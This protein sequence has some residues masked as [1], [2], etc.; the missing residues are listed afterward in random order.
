MKQ[1]CTAKTLYTVKH[2]YIYN[3]QFNHIHLKCENILL[4]KYAVSNTYNSLLGKM[5]VD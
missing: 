5:E 2:L 4:S 1:K 3:V